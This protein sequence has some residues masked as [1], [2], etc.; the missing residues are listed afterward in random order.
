M[1]IDIISRI[2]NRRGLYADLPP[3]LA[4]GEIGFCLDTR[5]M[6]IGNSP[7]YGNNTQVLTQF[8][9]N[10]QLITTRY[11]NTNTPVQ[12]STPR[13][14]QSK[15]NDF[16][17]IKD[18]GAV[19]DGITDDA[20]AINA[21]ITNLLQ[22]NP[23]SGNLSAT[24]YFPP[25][26]Y[27]INSS[28]NLYPYLT[29]QGAGINCT[30]ILAAP[31]TSI[32][33]MFQTADSLGQTGAN[34]GLNNTTLPKFINISDLMIS[35]NDQLISAFNCVRYLNICIK[36]CYMIGGWNSTLTPGTDSALSLLTIGNTINSSDFRVF[37]TTINNFSNAI[38]AP[39]PVSN[40][41]ISFSNFTNLWR[42]INLANPNFG[43]PHNMC[44]TNSALSSIA[45]YAIYNGSQHA[46]ISTNNFYS[47]TGGIYWAS[48]SSK[49]VSM[50]EV[51]DVLIG[52]TD[53]G[54]SNSIILNPGQSNLP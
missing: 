54:S 5:E 42:G 31:N 52:V 30:R 2:Q 7:G 49:N 39:D 16:A 1:A 27:I 28:I 12:G 45:D 41:F 14:L 29:I 47:A 19:G 24:L 4:E 35:T 15:L 25:G 34:I 44:I 10:D 9:Q 3:A 53:A 33:Y 51:F 38:L 32:N 13:T 21:A 36:D 8:S 40:T 46:T 11:Q 18:F 17:S 43:G 26:T 37:N 23:Q 48:T 50:G 22:G 6:F 20:P